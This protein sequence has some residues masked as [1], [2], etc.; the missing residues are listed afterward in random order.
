MLKSVTFEVV[1][2][3]RLACEGC[4]NR[5]A[6]ML[7]AVTG[8]ARVRARASDQRIEVQLDPTLV[9]DAT[10]AERL[11]DGGYETRVASATQAQTTAPE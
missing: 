11:R 9:D 8:I 10:V 6:R 5:V 3:Q 1:G 7:K 4:E 2:E